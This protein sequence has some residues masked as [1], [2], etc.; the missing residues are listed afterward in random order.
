MLG[1][2]V[3]LLLG[4]PLLLT[5]AA[6]P[7]VLRVAGAYG[8]FDMPEDRRV[9]SCPTPR[10]GGI[11][12]VAAF[13]LTL[14]GSVRFTLI[15]HELQ[16]V[17]GMSVVMFL[18]GVWDDIR[19][20]RASGRLFIQ[21][22]CAMLT[23]WMGGLGVSELAL[24]PTLSI[25]LPDIVGHL[26]A[27][28]V[29]VGAVNAVNMIDGLDGLAGGIVLIGIALLTYLNLLTTGDIHVAVF[30]CI[31]LIGVLLGFLRYNTHPAKIFMG[32]GGSNWLG[33]MVGVLMLVVMGRFTVAFQPSGTWG[34]IRL[35]GAETASRFMALPHYV[36]ETPIPF[37][38][39]IMCFAMPIFDTAA[40][41][42][43][44]LKNG[45]SP[46][47]PDRRHF[48]HTLLRLGLNQSQSV[49]A[50][51]FIALAAGLA[52][53]SPVI[54]PNYELDA[55]PYVVSAIMLAL[56]PLAMLLN[57]KHVEM[58]KLRGFQLSQDQ[59]CGVKLKVFLKQLE[60]ANRYV[61]YGILLGVPIFAGV[62]DSNLGYVALVALCLMAATKV[63]KTNAGDFFNSVAFTLGVIVLLVANNQHPI[64]VQLN[65]KVV[66]IQSW[67]NNLFLWLSG[68]TIL[69][70]VLTFRRRYL[71]F[72]PSDF[73]ILILPLSLL[74]VPEPYRSQYHVDIIALRSLVLF[75]GVHLLIRR[76]ATVLNKIRF[77]MV[78]A[79][80]F[81]AAMGVFGMR[82]MHL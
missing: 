25:A 60:L 66:E 58:F 69:V 50:I 8:L 61:I 2:H 76:Q 13:L 45:L 72:S 35:S 59:R 14:M 74:L 49:G 12:M 55:L 30:V 53:V 27:V 43:V 54:F 70:F 38:S 46:M 3:L 23:V 44:R 78:I 41:I 57:E 17:L 10:L 26:L 34:L 47:H 77:V 75:G 9:H 37:W 39:V 5:I 73:L 81:V 18:T 11:A 65:G 28:F 63:F 48:H 79:L 31:P 67:Y 82:F 4:I 6:T 32:D 62:V 24:S 29:V 52:G 1:I 19:P 16:T 15:S 71:I 22:A 56:F 80:A 68:S 21:V 20:L 40:V 7:L 33:F 42:I 36:Q 51:Y 64:A